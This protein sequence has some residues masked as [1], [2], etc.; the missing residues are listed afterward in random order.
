MPAKNTATSSP[1][2]PPES[3]CSVPMTT[4]AKSMLGP[5]KFEQP[6][7]QRNGSEERLVPDVPDSF[8]QLR[9]ER[10]VVVLALFLELRS[11]Q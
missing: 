2:S 11:H 6:E 5:T 4:M 10:R 3:P 9:P 7:D 1:T 8:E